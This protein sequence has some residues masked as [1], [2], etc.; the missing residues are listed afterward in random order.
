MTRKCGSC[1]ECCTA[2][3]IEALD[4]AAGEPCPHDRGRGTRRC[5]IYKDRPPE[6]EKFSCGWQQKVLP[7]S[8]RPD[9]TGLVLTV[10]RGKIG[11]ILVLHESEEGNAR[12][13]KA[14]KTVGHTLSLGEALTATQDVGCPVFTIS[15]DDKKKM[16]IR[17]T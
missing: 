6:C 1:S 10:Q 8:M 14:R 17:G 4:K 5:T 15:P 11:P 3:K 2:L 7:S 12:K 13:P 16:I 9:E